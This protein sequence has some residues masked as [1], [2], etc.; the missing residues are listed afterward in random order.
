[1]ATR[2]QLTG[3]QERVHSSKHSVQ[4]SPIFSNSIQSFNT[5]Y[6]CSCSFALL[7]TQ[8]QP[9]Q[10]RQFAGHQPLPRHRPTQ[11]ELESFRS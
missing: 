8:Q 11:A 5:F 9:H 7:L 1:M 2:V 3:V 6:I 4:K 10:Q